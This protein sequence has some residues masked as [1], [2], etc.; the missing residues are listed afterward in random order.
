M[1]R[2]KTRLKTWKLLS[3]N[4]IRKLNISLADNYGLFINGKFERSVDNSTFNVENPATGDILCKVSCGQIEDVN[5]AINCA[6]KTFEDGIWRNCD[7]NKRFKIL[8]NASQILSKYVLDIA[9]IESLQTGRPIR[10]MNAQLQRLP[11]WLE[12]FASLQR[13]YQ[14]IITPFQG[15]YLNYIHRVPLGVCGLITPWNHPMLIAIKKISVALATGNSIVCKPSELAPCSILEFAKILK[16]AGLPDGVFNVIPGFGHICGKTL[17]KSPLIK[18]IDIT[19]GTETGK[20]V[21]KFVGENLSYYTAELGGKAPVIIFDDIIKN[22]MLEQCINGIVFGSYIASGQT[23]IMAARILI[24]ENIYHK[25]VNKLINKIKKIK[26]GHP[27]DIKTQFG[28]VINNQSR[29]KIINFVENAK[30]EGGK[31]LCGGKIPNYL[32]NNKL[33]NGYFY[34]PTVIECDIKNAENMKCVKEEIFGP[35]IVLLK[36]KDKNEAIKLANNSE[37]GLAASIWTSNISLAHSI[38]NKLDV[39]IIW[40]NDHHRNDPSSPWGGMKNSGL[41]RENG[42]DAFREYTQSKSVIINYS[43]KPFDWFK[44][45]DNIRYS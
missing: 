3:N 45:D 30:K 10:E 44:D 13:V 43:D 26:C 5:K 41:G 1:L 7:I 20:I 42:Y 4:N 25:I 31:I 21:G 39:G 40:I 17:C 22:N 36:F 23:C 12:Y 9:M 37:F 8:I 29:Q 18:K 32:N 38:V 6:Y 24:Q 2:V 15:E 33:N 11:E 27:Q 28:P 19:G 35:V 16:N 14:G 34:E